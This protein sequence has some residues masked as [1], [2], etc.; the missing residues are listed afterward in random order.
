[1]SSSHYEWEAWQIEVEDCEE[2]D[3]IEEDSSICPVFSIE[4]FANIVSDEPTM[5]EQVL[6]PQGQLTQASNSTSWSAISSKLSQMHVPLSLH[7][8]VTQKIIDC[9][10]SA[11]TETHNKNRNNI[12]IIVA[13][14]PV[15][16]IMDEDVRPRGASKEAIDALDK[17][18][19]GE[20]TGQCVICL[21]EIWDGM[22]ARRMPCSHVYHQA[23]IV[24]WLDKSNFCPLCR[25][26]MPV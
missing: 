16:L 3:P 22:N 6:V 1:M 2:D 9:A 21:E 17:V 26:Q 24:S 19:D 7:A 5:M 13:L 12:P 15:R 23:C 8:T 25:F 18:E 11:I 10:R 20:F 14:S 4:I